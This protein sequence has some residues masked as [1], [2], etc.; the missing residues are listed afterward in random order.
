M[1]DDH[2]NVT[3]S[4]R[5]LIIDPKY[6]HLGASPDGHVKCS[7]CGDGVIVHFPAAIIFFWRPL[8]IY[9]ECT[10]DGGFT[11]KKKQYSCR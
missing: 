5:R 7:C 9:L 8:V 10:T 4:D 6:P 3:V 2:L 11:L 1:Q